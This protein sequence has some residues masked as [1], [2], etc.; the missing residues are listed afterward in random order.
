[1]NKIKTLSVISVLS[2]FVSTTFAEFSECKFN[3]GKTWKSSYNANTSFSGQ[4]L[5]HL[6]IWLGDNADYN[7]YW[8][9]AMVKAAA[10]NNLTPVI[11]AY[12]IAEYGKDN[13]L[14]DCDA[15][16]TNHC[17]GGA[18][19]IRTKWSSIIARYKSYAQGIAADFGT[20]KTTIWL[21]EPRTFCNTP[22][23]GII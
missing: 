8:E 7:Q 11:Y 14:S 6:A 13:G 3:F 23:Q 10:N 12:V 2:L 1:M 17:T 15:G 19:L 16:S 9:G 21:I 5:S 18:N 22:L 4:G 20:S